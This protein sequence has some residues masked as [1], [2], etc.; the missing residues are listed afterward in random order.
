M[1]F[2]NLKALVGRLNATCRRGLEGAAGLCLSRTN[3]NVEIE[4]WLVK[5][6]EP[7]ETD[8]VRN[9]RHYDVDPGRVS[10]D[11]TRSLDRLKTGNAR[12]PELS[13]EVLDLMREAWTLT[14]L[15]YGVYRIR[16]GYVLT[17][18]LKDRSL[19]ARARSASAELAK[20]PG[21]QLQ[22]DVPA[23][24][25][26]STEDAGEPGQLPAEAGAPRPATDSKTPALDQFTIDLTA[27]AV[28]GQLDPVIGRDAEVRQ[29]IDILTR[30]RQNNPILTGE[31]GLGKTAV[32]EGFALRVTAGDVPPSLR[33]IALHT[34][35]LGLL[36][37]GA[38]MKGEFENRLKSVIAEVPSA[39][40]TPWSPPWPVAARRWR[41]GRATSIKSCPERS[42]PSWPR[43]FWR[44]WPKASRW[45]ASTSA[46][47]TRA[48]S[49]TRSVDL[50]GMAFCGVRGYPCGGWGETAPRDW[51]PLPRS[52]LARMNPVKPN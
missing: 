15:E 24:V 33:G 38:G 22:K 36:Q 4:H 39:T 45:S 52:V 14:S 20:V 41:A 47:E 46:S 17:A 32:G 42:C 9:L 21:E 31:A 6:L 49:L 19:S 8:R 44:R 30:R 12:P 2:T 29:A 48:G 35:D 37:A 5:L 25:A 50:E 40:T 3:Y 16:S 43:S 10:R 18:L 1:G 13:A 34:L 7:A 51:G 28:K 11:L 26:G 27:R 23:L